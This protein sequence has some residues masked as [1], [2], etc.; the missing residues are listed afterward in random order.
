MLHCLDSRNKALCIPLFCTH[1]TFFKQN[2]PIFREMSHLHHLYTASSHHQS[3]LAFK[4]G[5]STILE[6]L[7]FPGSC[8]VIITY[9]PLSRERRKTDSQLESG[10]SFWF[11]FLALFGYFMNILW[12]SI[13]LGHHETGYW[14]GETSDGCGGHMWWRCSVWLDTGKQRGQLAGQSDIAI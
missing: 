11:L 5:V 9:N 13:K 2:P 10:N 1:Q 4:F 6:L 3:A 12:Y 14:W 7:H 8:N